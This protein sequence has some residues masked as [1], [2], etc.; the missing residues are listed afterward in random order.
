MGTAGRE[1]SMPALSRADLKNGA[2]DEAVRGE[3]E[4]EAA[5]GHQPHTDETHH[6][7]G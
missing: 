4:E 1:G 2:K 3:N 5:E 7:Q 6:L